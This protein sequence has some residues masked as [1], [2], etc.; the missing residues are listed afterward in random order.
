M[1]RNPGQWL[2]E[3][4]RDRAEKVAL[5]GTLGTG[6]LCGAGVTL[7]IWM[8]LG[9]AAGPAW[10][11][12]LG[13]PPGVV[14]LGAAFY[15]LFGL[16][17]RE[18]RS[19]D[20]KN[21]ARAEETIGQA[22]EDALTRELCGVAH[23]VKEIATIG[24]IDHLVATPDRLWVIETKYGFVPKSDFSE[25]LRRIARNVEGVRNWAPGTRVTGCLVFGGDQETRPKRVFDSGGEKI[26]AFA[27]AT[28]LKRELRAEARRE[29]GSRELARQVRE[30]GRREDLTDQSLA[31]G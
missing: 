27:N 31:A 11:V 29:G 13:L 23:N 8:A 16:A 20:M 18:W 24:D 21:G 19:V 9:T 17:D 1:K 6:W 14:L 4:L 25:T 26:L 2:R 12:W 22:I 10:T 30:L 5:L 7:W 15:E 3:R 28:L